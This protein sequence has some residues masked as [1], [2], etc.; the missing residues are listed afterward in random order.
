MKSLL[1]FT[2]N[3]VRGGGNRY[4]IDMANALES[5]YGQELLVGNAGGIFAEDTAR[6]SR[7]VEQLDALFVTRSR[8]SNIFSGFPRWRAS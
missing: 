5:D 1:I 7:P 8:I 3:Y 2:E 6:L 4:M